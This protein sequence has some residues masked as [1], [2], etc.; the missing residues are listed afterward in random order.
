MGID[1][2]VMLFTERRHPRDDPVPAAQA[3]VVTV[4]GLDPTTPPDGDDPVALAN[5]L[6]DLARAGEAD[7]LADYADPACRST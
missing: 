3:G 1:R 7:R 4:P 6:M 2:L 5:W